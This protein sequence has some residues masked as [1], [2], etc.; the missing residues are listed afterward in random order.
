MS[1]EVTDANFQQEVIQSPIPVLIDFW[2]EWCG[3]CRQLGP[4]VDQLAA[5][6]SG[7]I[8]VMKMNIDESPDTPSKLG[9]R[10]IPTLMLFRDGALVDTKVGV[11]PKSSLSQW[12]DSVLQVA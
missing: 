12:I 7:R 2:A 10:G 6:F 11:L 8:K 9:I 1:N 5:D 4:I 3:P